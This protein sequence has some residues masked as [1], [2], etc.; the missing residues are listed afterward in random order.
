MKENQLLFIS[1][2]TNYFLVLPIIYIYVGYLFLVGLLNADKSWQAN[3]E[4]SIE[5]NQL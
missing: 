2:K 1:A 5:Q 3:N 4:S